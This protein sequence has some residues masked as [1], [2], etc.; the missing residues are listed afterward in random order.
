MNESVPTNLIGFVNDYKIIVVEG[1]DCVGK[2]FI[3]DNLSRSLGSPVYRPDYNYW[4]DHQLPQSMRWIIG[5]G[6][7][8][9]IAS[10]SMHIEN[11][12]LIDRGILSGM[13]YTSPAV[14][15]GYKQ[16]ID[17]FPRKGRDGFNEDYKVLHLI[18]GTDE[19]SFN[20]FNEMRGPGGIRTDYQT[21]A[22]KTQLFIDYARLMG[23]EYIK[24]MNKYDP[25]YAE[26]VKGKCGSCGHYSYGV[27]K[28]PAKLG[29]RVS[30]FNTR[31]EYS[32]ELEV[33]DR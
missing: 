15:I 14:G 7:F 3:L 1:W 9:A 6:I 22:Q 31:C 23:L 18:V 12:L 30:A 8:D 29:Q 21:V 33:Q 11:K 20:K 24:V 25:Q 28:N 13:V 32:N 19:E 4:R 10:K 2:S 17:S 16:L 26:R 5:A 27:C